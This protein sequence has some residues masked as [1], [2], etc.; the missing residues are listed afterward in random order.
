MDTRLDFK[1]RKTID[2]DQSQNT[3]LSTQFERPLQEL[4]N[5]YFSSEIGLS[6][7]KL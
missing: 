3:I 5:G 7:H 4:L 1:E 6:K 2:F